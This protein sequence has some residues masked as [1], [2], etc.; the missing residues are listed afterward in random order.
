MGE[1]KIQIR[2]AN[3]PLVLRTDEDVEY[4]LELAKYVEEKINECQSAGVASLLN[5]VLLAS[6]NIADELFKQK[7]EIENINSLL[8]NKSKSISEYLR[9]VLP[10]AS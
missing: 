10:K 9:Q 3:R 8:E 1:N 4:I 7:G 5:A 6:I 2:I